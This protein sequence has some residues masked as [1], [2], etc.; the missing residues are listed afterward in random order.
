MNTLQEFLD[1]IGGDEEFLML[2]RRRNPRSY[3]EFIEVLYSD[4]DEIL[5]LFEADAQDF[6]K[7]SEDE[8]NRT[9]VRDLRLRYYVARHDVDEG[10]HVDIH[11]EPRNG[12]Y[13]WLGEAKLDE[14]PKYVYKGLRQLTERY[15]RG[16]P[17]HNCGGVLIY[18]QKDNCSGR[19]KRYQETLQNEMAKEET[20]GLEIYP[21]NRRPGLAFF[22]KFVLPRIGPDAP[23]YCVRHMAVS[24]YRPATAAKSQD[25]APS[26]T[27]ER[28]QADSG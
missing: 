27:I 22:S 18:V 7:W 11:V 26:E 15:A 1:A 28:F 8:I 9:L 16:T 10:G 24:L 6:M 25:G 17:G 13:S 20:E 3:D 5:G 19:L 12:K 21:C 23:R 2:T 4:L 14:G